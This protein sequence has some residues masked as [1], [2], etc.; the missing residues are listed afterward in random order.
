MNFYKTRIEKRLLRTKINKYSTLKRVFKRKIYLTEEIKE[1]I[2]IRIEGEIENFVTILIKGEQGTFKSSAGETIAKIINPDFKA[3]NFCFDYAE[4]KEK[5]S[6]SDPR[7]VF[8]LDEQVFLHGVGSQRIIEEIQT[9]IETLRKRQNSMIVISPEE[10]Y[11]PESIFTYTL[12]TIDRSTKGVCIYSNR[13]HEIRECVNKNHKDMELKVRLAVRKNNEYIGLIVL[14]PEWN[15][16][17]WQAY[18]E[19]KKIF[20]SRVLKSDHK[21]S[22]YEKLA[23]QI[24]KN[25]QSHFY[26]T[27]KQLMLLLEKTFP[28]LT[29][30]EKNLL[31]EEIKIMRKNEGKN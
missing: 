25:P 6:K 1:D 31:V 26:K 5:L 28:N 4:F 14:F 11:F 21:K 24:I 7:E 18:E 13:R 22:N 17:V 16:D 3:H 30:G 9:L 12:E 8:I 29:V 19:N 20:M 10:K 2:K 15:N 27:S 23:K